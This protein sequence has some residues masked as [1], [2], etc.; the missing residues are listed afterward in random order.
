MKLMSMDNPELPPVVSQDSA[1]EKAQESKK[2]PDIDDTVRRSSR[3]RRP[4]L[5]FKDY[6]SP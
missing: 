2:T 3:Q 5:R 1:E 4:P 6:V